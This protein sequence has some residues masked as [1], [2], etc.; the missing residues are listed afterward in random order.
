VK[1]PAR[2]VIVH[3]VNVVSH[4]IS[5]LAVKVD[6]RAVDFEGLGISVGCDGYQWLLV[7]STLI[8]FVGFLQLVMSY[9]LH[10]W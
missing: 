10:S 7:M 4:G 6:R 1:I 5:D 8:L 3:R 2:E 9:L